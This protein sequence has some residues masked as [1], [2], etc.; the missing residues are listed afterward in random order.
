MFL[1]LESKEVDWQ[2]YQKNN[3]S[4]YVGKLEFCTVPVESRRGVWNSL[5]NTFSSLRLHWSNAQSRFLTRLSKST[6]KYI[7]FSNDQ[8]N[9]TVRNHIWAC[10]LYAFYVPCSNSSSF[11]YVFCTNRL[12]RAEYGFP[13]ALHFLSDLVHPYEQ[14]F[15]LS[16][17]HNSIAA[18]IVFDR[19][20]TSH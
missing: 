19:Q 20:R 18:C 7:L 11:L 13:L 16:H 12:F 14:L 8:C 9:Y 5:L 15:I 17:K 3:I 6:L 1:C 2:A 4:N 10:L